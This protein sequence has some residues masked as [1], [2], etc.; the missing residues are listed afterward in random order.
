MPH[1]LPENGLIRTAVVTGG[2]AFQVPP[3][4]EVFRAMPEV[5]F[6]PQA[7]DEFTFDAELAT[8]YD[9]V[10][11]YHMHRFKPGDELPWYQGNMFKTLERLGTTPQG[12][13]MLHHSLVA[14]QEWP[15]WSEVIGMGDRTMRS[16]HM[17]QEVHVEVADPEHPVTRGLTPWTMTD[18][19][20]RMPDA[21]PADG[22]TILLTTSHDPSARTLAWARTFRESRVLCYQAGHDFMAFDDPNFRAVVHNGIRW[23]ARR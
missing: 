17:G 15:F 18:E 6:Y 3:F 20:Y 16:F 1:A 22:N 4:Y 9:V 13:L 23:L 11:F 19:T 2:H 7:L 14:F 5:D 21:D 10:V 8:A 12:I